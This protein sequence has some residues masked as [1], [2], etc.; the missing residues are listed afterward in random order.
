VSECVARCYADPNRP[1]KIVAVEPL[2]GGRKPQAFFSTC[3]GDSAE[4]VLTRYAARWSIEVTYHDA[5]GHL[6]FE[7]PQ[8]W[9]KRAVQRTA[10]VAMLLYT[11]VALWFSRAGHRHYAPPHR[12]W[13]L[14]KTQA[15]FAD[16]LATLRCQSVKKK[17]LSMHLHVR[18][19]RNVLKTLM[20]VVNQAA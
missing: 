18:G 16:M 11:L 1:L 8:G 14:G 20:H 2:S 19:S 7:E 12:P 9:T 4:A 5:K 10:P 15:S 13:Y 17:V 6:G 3:A